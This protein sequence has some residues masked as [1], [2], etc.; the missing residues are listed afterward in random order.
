MRSK[1]NR[2]LPIL[3][4]ALMLSSLAHA[5]V[6]VHHWNFNNST[7]LSSLLA[8]NQGSGSITHLAG[9]ISAIQITSNTGQGF[10]ITN[11]NARNGDVA[12]THLRFNDP[13]GGELEFGLPTTGFQNVVVR[14]ATRRSGSGAGVQ[15][16]SYSTDGTTFTLFD[17][18]FPVDGNPTLQTLN[19][20]NIAA[21]NNNANFKIR[22]AFA[23]GTGGTVGNNRFDNFTLEGTTPPQLVHY[24]NFNNSTDQTTLLTPTQ[25]NGS[26]AH[27]AGGTSAIQTTSNAT[28]QGFENTNPNARN[29]D[30]AG[31]HLRFNNPIGGQLEFSLPT[32]GFSNV[33]VK[34][35]TR[36][37][38]QGAGTQYISYSTDGSTYTLHDSIFP[39]DGDPTVQTVNFGTIAAA[40]NNPNFKIRMA[41]AQGSAGTGGNNRIDNF[42]LEGSSMGGVD[43][44]PP[45]ANLFPANNSS[46][47]PASIRPRIIFSEPMRLAGAGGASFT[48]AMA[49]SI[50]QLL[51][52]PA[53]T[54]V[55]FSSQLS[56]DTLTIVPAAALQANATYVLRI[57]D[58]LLSDLAGNLLPNNNQTSFSILPVQTIFQAGDLLPVAY[59]MNATGTPDA[60]AL[61][62]Q[63]NILPG[64]NI[65]LTDAKFTTNNPAQCP[66]GITWTAPAGGVARGT[67]L[68]IGTDDASA[69]IGTVTGSTFGLSSAGDQVIV[70]AGT[71]TNPTY[72]TALSANAWLQT[73]TTCSGSFSMLP[74]GL[75]D[76]VNAINLSTAPGNAAG[77]SV[78]AFYNGPQSGANLRDSILNPAYWVVS[79]SGTPAQVWPNWSFPGPPAVASARVLNG[80]QIEVVF[81]Q[82]MLAASATSLARYKQLAGIQSAVMTNNGSLRDTVVLTVSP[83]FAAGQA[84][85]LLIDSVENAGGLAMFSAFTFNFSYNPTISFNGRYL[86]AEENAGSINL[87]LNLQFPANASFRIR[88]AAGTNASP[89][90]YNFATQTVQLSANS[91]S[92]SLPVGIVDDAN[93]E[94]D[95][96]IIFTIDS[97]QGVA[98]SGPNYFTV[99]I[100]DNDRTLPARDSAVSM[101]LVTSF[102]PSPTGSTT[103]VVV[104][105]RVSKRL[106]TTS[107]IENRFDIINFNNPAAPVTISSVSMA[108]YG[109]LT[110]IAVKPGLLAVA[111]PNVNEQL[112][113]SV[114]FFDTLGNFKAQVTVGAL[115]DMITFTPD[116]TKL[117]VANEGQPNTTFSVDPEGSISIIDLSDTLITQSDVTTID[118]TAFN[119][120]EAALI[121]AGVRKGSTIG[122]LSQNL[123][124]EYIT[125]AAD[126]SKA[127]VSL[128]E[129]NAIAEINLTNNTITAIRGLGTK[130]NSLAGNGFDAS[131]NIPEVLMV[132]WPTKMYYMPDAIGSY[133]VNGTTY[134]VSA[135]EG[136][137]REYQALNE[138]TTVG[139]ASTVL[140]PTRFP[141]AAMLKENHALGRFRITNL[142]GDNDGDGDYDDVINVGSRSF[143]I[144]NANTGAQVFDSKNQ[145]ELITLLDPQASAIFNADHESNTRKNRSRSKGP[146][147]EGLTMATVN[148]RTFTFVGLERVGGVVAY[149][150][151]DPLNAVYNGYLNPRSTSTVSGDRGPE[152]MTYIAANESGDGHAYIVVANEISGTLSIIRL[153]F[154]IPPARY[155]LQIL[156]ASDMEG[157]LDAPKD[158]PNFAA[159]IDK[160]E[161][162]YNH[163]VILSSGDNFIPSPFLSAGEDPSLQTPL[164][165]AT[166]R[167]FSG[168]QAVRP[169]IGR[170][171]ISILNL[172]GFN[173]SVFGNHEFDLGT[174]ELNSMIGVDIRNN[175]ADRRWVG[176]QFPYLSANLNFSADANLS[177]LVTADGQADTAFRTPANITANS[178]KKGI[179]RSVVITRGGEKIG[180]V[181]ATTQ[182]LRSISSPGAT[183][184]V[185][186]QVNDMPALAAILQPVIDSLRIGQGI[187]KIIV[188]SHLQQLSLEQALAP[189]L[190]GVDVIIAGGSHSLLADG[191]D[192]LRPGDVAVGTYPQI[193]QDA[194]GN[195]LLLVNTA[196]EYRYVGRLVVAFDSLGVIDTTLLN[197]MINGAYATD[198][199]GVARVWG[200]YAAAFAP[201]TKG[202][203]VKALTDAVQTVIVAKD[204]NIF[205]KASVFLEGRREFTRTE[206]TNLGNLTSDANLWQARQAD[207]TVTL[208]LK[209]GGGIRQAMGTVNAVGSN[210]T[211]EPTAA[212]PSAGKQA[213]DISQ[214]DIEN[215]LRFNNRL[216]VLTIPVSGIKALLEHGVA[217]TAPGATPG[218][219]PQV[220]GMAFSYDPTLPV[221]SRIRSVVRLDSLGNIIDTLVR[222]GQVHGNP[223]RTYKLVTLNFLAGGGDGYPF[224]PY[225]STRVDLDTVLTAAGGATFA[226]P[227]SEQDAF[228]EYMLVR[229]PASSPYAIAET[230]AAQDFRIQD[231]SRR[232]EGLLPFDF[233]AL[234]APA[235]NSRLETNPTS[236]TPVQIVWNRAINAQSYKW[237]LTSATGNFAPGLVNLLSNNNGLD[238]TLTLT[239]RGIDSL[240]ASLGVAPGD[241]INT[242]WTVKS[243]YNN[244]ADSTLAAPFNLRLVRRAI[245]QPFNLLNPANNAR[246]VGIPGDNTPVNINWTRSTNATTYRWVAALTT[247]NLSSPLVTLNA[248]NNGADSVLT[249][250]LGGI[251]A[252]L[253]SLNIQAGDSVNL[254]WS[255]RAINAAGTDSILASAPRNIR[256]VRRQPIPQ[257]FT[258]LNPANNARVVG[259]PGD[260]TPVNINW[261]RSTNATTYRWV[262]ALS[263]GNLSSPLVTLNANNNGADSVLTLTLG[264]IDALLA[265]LNIQPGD[266]VNL[267]WSV[268]AINAAGTDSILASAPRNIRL[269]RQVAAPGAFTLV[270]PANNTRLLTEAGN[271]SAVTINWRASANATRYE[272]MVDFPTGDFSS[273]IFT[274][275]ARN[276]GADTVLVLLNRSIDSLLNISGVLPGDSSDLIW[277]VRA[278][279]A[280][281]TRL[282][283][284]PFNIRLVRSAQISA[285]NLLSPSNNGRVEV[286]GPASTPVNITW[287]A[288]TSQAAAPIRYRWLADPAGN[289]SNPALSFAS[290]GNGANNQL[291]LTTGAIDTLLAANGIAI[292]D[293]LTL[294]WTVEARSGVST[295]LASSTFT[296]R[297]IR[298][299]LTTSVAENSLVQVKLYP[300]PAIAQATVSA[301]AEIRSLSIR[302]LVGAEVKRIEANSNDVILELHDLPAGTYLVQGVTTAGSFTRR[303][304]VTR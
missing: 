10:D 159:V 21:V 26:I 62:T 288:A 127:W 203:N 33:I 154:N 204:G 208:S 193:R 262:A 300:N 231:L 299:G 65:Q 39:V 87:P 49:D 264:G 248:N 156:H 285:F 106:F 104:Y 28:G 280:P 276:N 61:L 261:T 174:G 199:A 266:S 279:N 255:V 67:V 277:T 236:T 112:P 301:S 234:L 271:N 189:L 163:T 41:F 256:L 105:D 66:G 96:F 77:L 69:N 182:V 172:I 249:L 57:R 209:N 183:T 5:Q 192:I 162:E 217:Q 46:Q 38:G 93:V 221:N 32:S 90:D 19:F 173:A 150:V 129:N 178:Q 118:F 52:Q 291:T 119:A 161:D 281:L 92:I 121:A 166:S 45:S 58:G 181:G 220:G 103:E 73:N 44:F 80:T 47:H 186:P 230:P 219:F 238:T 20:G 222:N 184:V 244:G 283:T 9:G 8:P 190:N 158:A 108:P 136:D 185:G 29:S 111:S 78:N 212:N 296:V 188:L 94:D 239:V 7:S 191:N 160:L 263:T 215:S 269:V 267:Q 254:Q 226:V 224:A 246:V 132:N 35:G 16:I 169:A 216:S 176:A 272:W 260:N 198:S 81:T 259:I 295:R 275:P 242:R 179:A 63:V 196:A 22:I 131:D 40:N 6:L 142:N 213:G 206:E 75:T 128:Q 303:L 17:S 147:P 250:T 82:D 89:A 292:G 84:Y 3:L 123:E 48:A 290:N 54:A 202:A 74:A 4:S 70:Y 273:P 120:Q 124:P 298:V 101:T 71:N 115:P 43:T 187:N 253:A 143:S 31:A 36:R 304:V 214:L 237:S 175:G 247:G 144:W 170:P 157:G 152:T 258:L 164:R 79:G 68:V 165:T 1:L 85:S 251:D 240:L 197:P 113:G 51:L 146:E 148:G 126:N 232:N 167:Y 2:L 302:N 235:N 42:T 171:D 56:G 14:Y 25:G 200:N 60:I 153:N 274:F 218:R 155:N 228:A 257:P 98:L 15:Y 12:G 245:P 95:E 34:Y 109:G 145:L 205:G 270:G 18:I 140:D 53:N 139:A 227:G 97:L 133:T 86:V 116:G 241:S 180:I 11:P 37:S 268:R 138:R 117:L 294:Q 59:R 137:E 24:W 135:N 211:L 91:S 284:A 83:A 252:L 141:H 289:F 243:F 88:V 207:P 194:A 30:V 151:T 229:H 55:S 134:L 100:R 23:Q 76:G 265:S 107:S 72:I 114:V 177:Y 27:I 225:A 278:I 64:T 287:E 195:P 102:D 168:T 50:V 282:A 125:V 210:V 201:G 110:S 286:R 13:I 99:Y 297:F 233:A 223:N 149:D 130:D 293:S 122:T